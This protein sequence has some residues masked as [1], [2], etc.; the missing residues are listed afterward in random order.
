MPTRL[1]VL[2]LGSWWAVESR[3]PDLW[4]P[5]KLMGSRLEVQK[6]TIMR[7]PI[8]NRWEP[9]DCSHAMA[10]CWLSPAQLAKEVNNHPLIKISADDL[11]D[12][13]PFHKEKSLNSFTRLCYFSTTPA[14]PPPLK[15]R[16]RLSPQ[17]PDWRPSS[18]DGSHITVHF[19]CLR[20][21]NGVPTESLSHNAV[22]AAANH[23]GQ[24]G[25]F[26]GSCRTL[27]RTLGGWAAL[28]R[29]GRA[30]KLAPAQVT[31]AGKVP[32]SHTQLSMIFKSRRTVVIFF[33]FY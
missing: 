19:Y 15:S 16:A 7:D 25:T 17:D 23:Q 11:F 31:K 9:P 29:L 8:R 30:L 5:W 21:A 1:A 10:R 4:E 20:A 22:Q 3:R 32:F 33:S 26:R 14:C 27:R 28:S 18:H 6:P 24:P 2:P 13:H 12:H